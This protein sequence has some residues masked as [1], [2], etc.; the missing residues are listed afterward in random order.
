MTRV[1]IALA[2]ATLAT[3][4]FAAEAPRDVIAA[5]IKKEGMTRTKS[6]HLTFRHGNIKDDY[7]LQ[8]ILPDR[9]HMIRSTAGHKLE[10]I[11]I[12]PTLYTSWDGAA[13]TSTSVAKS[14]ADMQAITGILLNAMT[15]VKE[16][17]ATKTAGRKQRNFTASINWSNRGSAH[18]GTLRVA[19]GSANKL[20]TSM[21][22]TGSCSAQPCSFHQDFNYDSTIKIVAPKL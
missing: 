11:A 2:I 6:I 10:L 19:I 14:P 8:E 3:A 12:S 7:T 4:S 16:A 18:Q 22:F 5:A 17:A 20:P 21:D 13:W 15:Q 9:L 1:L